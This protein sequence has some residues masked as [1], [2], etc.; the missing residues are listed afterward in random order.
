MPQSGK[1]PGP[2]AH[3]NLLSIALELHM[4]HTGASDSYISLGHETRLRHIEIL[5]KRLKHWSRP[6]EERRD[7]DEA[8]RRVLI[9]ALRE[10]GIKFAEPSKLGRDLKPG[11]LV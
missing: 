4:N 6:L 5:T 7:F 2:G 11:C 9:V 3:I 8:V 10:Q 1:F